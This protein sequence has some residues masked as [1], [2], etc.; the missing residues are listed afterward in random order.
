MQFFAFLKLL[1]QRKIEQAVVFHAPWW[2]GFALWLARVPR[3]VGRYSQWHSFLFFNF[4]VR[5]KRSLSQAHESEYNMELI[6]LLIDE[7]YEMITP[8]SLRHTEAESVLKKFQ[9]SNIKYCLVHPGMNG[10]ALNWPT[11]S[12]QLL[13]ETL[14]LNQHVVIT[15]TKTDA[16]YIQPLYEKLEN[17]S[18]VTWL[19]EKLSGDELIAILQKAE[20]VVA[21]STG[22]AHLSASLGTPT[23]GIYSNVIAE[24]AKRWGPIGAKVM[25]FEPKSD[26]TTEKNPEVMKEIEVAEVL[27]AIKNFG[28]PIS[29]PT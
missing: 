17:H 20:V 26:P 12:Y 24:S 10:S 1:R 19:H 28:I 8:L 4:G 25:V 29:E 27:N 3:R 15:G 14:L 18:S 7:P 16:P 9:L 23:I 11:E 2:I 22:V 21:P 13:V 6:H 5:Q